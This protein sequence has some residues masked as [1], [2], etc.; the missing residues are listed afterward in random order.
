MLAAVAL[1]VSAGLIGCEGSRTR[2]GI[3]DFDTKYFACHDHCV[4][5]FQC[6]DHDPS[7]DDTDICVSDCRNSL[8]D[9]CGNENQAAAND[10][11]GECVDKNCLEFWACMVLDSAPDCLDFASN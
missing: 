7:D 10:K 9:N 1:L 11:I 2:E 6:E 3:D 5:K 4:K 8:E